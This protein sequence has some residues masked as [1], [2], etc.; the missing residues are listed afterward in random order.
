MSSTCKDYK[1][2]NERKSYSLDTTGALLSEGL[3]YYHLKHWYTL[4]DRKQF[5][6]TNANCLN[7]PHP[8]MWD[9]LGVDPDL[10]VPDIHGSHTVD[11][12][13]DQHHHNEATIAWLDQFFEP[14]LVSLSTIADVQFD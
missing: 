2:D 14:S 8:E 3:Y 6:I 12:S 5:Y 1:W 13:Q 10:W 11:L 4:F 7:D 9:F